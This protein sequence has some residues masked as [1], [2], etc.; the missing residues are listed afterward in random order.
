MVARSVPAVRE[1]LGEGDYVADGN[2]IAAFE[3]ALLRALRDR[4]DHE[5]HAEICPEVVSKY[6]IERAAG[7]TFGVY[8]QAMIL[9]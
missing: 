1:L 5:N 8:Q 6:S 9:G 4:L 3:R 2:N 7:E